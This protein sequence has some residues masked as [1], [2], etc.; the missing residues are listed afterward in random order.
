MFVR[1]LFGAVLLAA[2]AL[3]GPPLTTI[4]DVLYK[5]DGTRFNGNLTIAW[6]SFQAVDRSAIVTQSTSVK[7]VDGSLRVQLV[8]T[9]TATPPVYYTVTYNSDGR[10]QF[11][12]TWAVPSSTQPL[13]VRDVRTVAPAG[14]GSQTG[15][16]TSAGG[17]VAESDVV[18]LV[19]DL[20]VRPTKGP[21][22]AAGRVAMV[23]ATGSLE[24]VTG[25]AS[26]CVRVDGSSGPCGATATSFVDGDSPAG[27]VD[28]ANTA[29]SL[30][31]MPD[32]VSSLAVY[33]NG[34]LQKIGQDYDLNGHSLVFIPAAA[35]QPGD[36]LLASYRLSGTEADAPLIFPN[37]QV[38]CS[39]MGAST[40]STGLA[41]I[42]ICT[43]PAG[44]LVPGDRLA[45]HFD[46]MHQGS[47]SGFSF[48]IR[49]GATTVLHR[50]ASAGDTLATGRA[51][52][53]LTATGVQLSAQSWGT[54]LPL[55]ASVSTASDPFTSGLTIDFQ[56]AAGQSQ[57]VVTLRN[58][59]VLRFP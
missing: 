13:R 6:S 29:F 36:T 5:A 42:G 8:P 54:L 30:S 52:A 26:D 27:I 19:A 48:E 59:T 22:Y 17:P 38:L 16:D 28:G 55:T 35:P 44:I 9:T 24:S 25:G 34:L 11:K 23:N 49:W 50:D 1:S 33:R 51:D 4:Q 3:A 31:S 45:I 12:E 43:I 15:S 53:G 14:S 18:G 41:S 40:N 58:F 7:V 47:A 21:G 2:T 46:L 32:P 10:I 37:T 20:G 56:A 39:G 57:D